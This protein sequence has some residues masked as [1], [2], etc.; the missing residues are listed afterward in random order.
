MEILVI[1]LVAK[2]MLL[3]YFGVN[4]VPFEAT[5]RGEAK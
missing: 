1:R 4:P 3:D 5:G 2:V